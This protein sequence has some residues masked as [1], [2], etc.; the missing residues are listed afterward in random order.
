MLRNTSTEVA[1]WYVIPADKKW[2]MRAAVNSVIVE[3]MKTLKLH[4]PKLTRVQH[5]D[6]K[7]ARLILETE[8]FAK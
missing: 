4:Y 5:A 1:P 2:F 6:L 7:K 3:Q 8:G